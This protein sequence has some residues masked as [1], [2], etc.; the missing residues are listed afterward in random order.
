[1]RVSFCTPWRLEKDGISDYSGYMVDALKKRGIDI[2]V[3][4]L[5]PYIG[6][7]AYYRKIAHDASTA[8]IVHIQFNYLYFNGTLPYRNTFLHFVKHLSI[9]SIMTVH[10]FAIGHQPLASGFSR[11]LN[12][13]LFNNTLFLWNAL[14]RNLH[15]SMY[16]RVDK[17]IVHTQCQAEMILPLLD[18]AGKLTVIP[19]AIPTVREEE[20]AIASLEAKRVLHLE[21][22]IVLSTFGF[23]N[24]RKGYKTVLDAIMGLPDNIIFLIAGGKMGDDPVNNK[25]YDELIGEIARCGLKDRVKITGY[26]QK[27]E[28][29]LVMAATDIVLAPFSTVAGSGSLSLTIAYHKPIIASDAPVHKEINERVP[30]LELF[31]A[32]DYLALGAAIKRVLGDTGRI[33]VLSAASREYSSRF[34][35]GNIADMTI[36]LY[37]EVIQDYRKR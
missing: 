28:I 14:L 26:L 3:I 30:C 12:R 16:N 6:E 7:R 35:Y 8:D 11:P 24:C 33:K 15:R 34:G 32:G 23:I 10:E 17:V 5:R 2:G 36:R 27:E 31:K 25:Y 22:K 13:I 21:G 9:P 19:H 29:P 20:I 18:E 1:M 4:E 37:E